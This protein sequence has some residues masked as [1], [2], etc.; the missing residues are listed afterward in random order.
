MAIPNNEFGYYPDADLTE[1]G[2][3]AE[4]IFNRRTHPFKGV[5]IVSTPVGEEV[6]KKFFKDSAGEAEARAR[7]ALPKTKDQ[8]RRPNK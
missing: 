2:D 3:R 4:E 8:A 5:I 6:F 1:E 7:P